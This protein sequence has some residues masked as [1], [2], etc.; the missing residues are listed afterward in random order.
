MQ[1]L[2]ITI[3]QTNEGEYQYDIY[4][5]QE[6]FEN[7][8]SLDGGVC[9]TTIANALE[10]AYKQAKDTIKTYTQFSDIKKHVTGNSN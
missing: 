1:E 8:N 5:N 10:M 6:A 2:I 4:D 3:S 9:T 7:G